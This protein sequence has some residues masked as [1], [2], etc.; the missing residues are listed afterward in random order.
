M[1]RN[2]NECFFFY[3]S[4][5]SIKLGYIDEEQIPFLCN[6]HHNSMAT[7]KFHVFICTEGEQY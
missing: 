4:C 6:D 2:F 1:V 5:R 3:H 7:F